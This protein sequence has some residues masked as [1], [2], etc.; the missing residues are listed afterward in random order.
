MQAQ[1]RAIR[2]KR[3]ACGYG[4]TD[5]A[6]QIDISPSWL[7]RIERD[8]AQP[9]PGVLKRIAH[10]LHHERATRDVIAEITKQEAQGSDEPSDE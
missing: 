8:Q 9:S 7:S 5:F 2:R 3:E 6:R 10:A 4:L 1:G